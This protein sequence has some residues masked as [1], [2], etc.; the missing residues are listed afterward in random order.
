MPRGQ[1]PYI[2]LPQRAFW[3][4]AIAER[5]PLQ[6]QDVWTPK[7]PITADDRIA[8]FGSCFAQHFSA[9]LIERGY[10]WFDA[11]LA[12]VIFDDQLCRSFGYGIFSAR[13]GNIYTAA[14]LLQWL[15]WTF[16]PAQV[17]KE[18][19]Q[20]QGRWFDPFRPTIEPDGFANEAEVLAARNQTLSALYDLVHRTDV[21]VFTLGL[22][23]A[24]ANKR[25]GYVYPMCPGTA[26]GDFD[27]T[28]HGFVNFTFS[29]IREHMDEAINLLRTHNPDIRI[30]LTVSPVPLTATASGRHVLLATTHS[31][32]VLRAVAGEIAD[33]YN[34]VDYF[35]SYEMITGS[36]FRSNFFE[37]NLRSITPSGVSFVMDSFFESMSRSFGVSD[38]PANRQPEPELRIS[39]S[40]DDIICEEAMLEAFRPDSPR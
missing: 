17:P 34:L 12:P 38:A 32:A 20:E 10:R 22:T 1:H 31:K 16:D 15:T 30:L 28:V 5:P 23:E 37:E 24:W 33:G 19:W 3:R 18:V 26:A 27:P 39:E 11:E 21:F 4:S 29:Q 40:D 6:I 13:T 8:T 14:S 9:A 35:P 7:F 36:P 25:H 2:G